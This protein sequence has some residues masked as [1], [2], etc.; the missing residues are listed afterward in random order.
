M[1]TFI[2]TTFDFHFVS[3][4]LPLTFHVWLILSRFT[5]MALLSF[6]LLSA[7]RG[8][9]F[10][11]ASEHSMNNAKAW[12]SLTAL[13]HVRKIWISF[14]WHLIEAESGLSSVVNFITCTPIIKMPIFFET[15]KTLSQPF[16][17]T[18]MAYFLLICI[19]P[20]SAK[21]KLSFILIYWN[22]AICP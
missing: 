1:S 6:K 2:H 16:W 22:S 7:I 4:L 13:D 14:M 3:G 19:L 15:H 21:S 20:S 11:F 12:Q 8:S 5:I 9:F 10:I 18:A 17:F